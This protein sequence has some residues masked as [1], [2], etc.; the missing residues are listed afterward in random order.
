MS[1]N[2]SQF[3]QLETTKLSQHASNIVED[4]PGFHQK[5]ASIRSTGPTKIFASW[6]YIA[7]IKSVS[8]VDHFLSVSG[9]FVS[10]QVDQ[11]GWKLVCMDCCW[12]VSQC[13]DLLSSIMLFFHKTATI[14]PVRHVLF[15]FIWRA[16]YCFCH[17][18]S[19]FWSDNKRITDYKPLWFLFC[20]HE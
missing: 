18:Y 13:Q 17:L 1:V 9:S 20:C 19:L 7:W 6:K 3:S 10:T 8:W 11:V 4:Q 15:R 16:K 12:K 2:S 5:V 14:S